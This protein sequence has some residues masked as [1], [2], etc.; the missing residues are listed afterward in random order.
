MKTERKAT[1]SL[2]F[3]GFFK[4][5]AAQENDGAAMLHHAENYSFGRFAPYLERL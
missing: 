4:V 3:Q 1:K 5:N 2:C